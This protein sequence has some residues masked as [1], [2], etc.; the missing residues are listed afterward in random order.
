MNLFFIF[1][2]RPDIA[3]SEEIRKQLDITMDAL[4]NPNRARPE[5]E[6]VCGETAR[7]QASPICQMCQDLD[8]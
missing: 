4:R 1:D 3:T 8:E 2:E 7:H 5:G 6:W